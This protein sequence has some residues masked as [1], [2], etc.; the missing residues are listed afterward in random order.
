MPSLLHPRRTPFWLVAALVFGLVIL[1]FLVHLT[2]RTVLGDYSGGAAGSFFVDYL[3]G[4]LMFQWYSW[5]LAL[6]P[7]IIVAVWRILAFAPS[8]RDSGHGSG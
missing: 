8:R 3:R 5:V 2:G 6:G 7:L 1:P 4:L